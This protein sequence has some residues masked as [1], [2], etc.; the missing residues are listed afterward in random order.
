VT[1][2]EVWMAAVPS[3]DTVSK[4]AILSTGG[5]C[6]DDWL[7]YQANAYGGQSCPLPKAALRATRHRVSAVARWSKRPLHT[8]ARAAGTDI[9]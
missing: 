6:G 5:F 7:V 3:G 2:P 1:P 8:G 9:P 4:K